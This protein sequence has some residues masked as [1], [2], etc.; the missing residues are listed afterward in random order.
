M[1]KGKWIRT[2]DFKQK[3]S[4]IHKGHYTSE[5]TKRKIS[6]A[7]KISQRGKKLSDEH[8]R[9]IGVSHKN[10]PCYKNPERS[11]KISLAVKGKRR[12]LEQRRRISESHKGLTPWNKGKKNVQ[13]AW[14]KGKPWSLETKLKMSRVRNKGKT[15]QTYR[16]MK[17]EGWSKW[18]KSVFERDN[19]TCQECGYKGDKLEPHHI[20]PKSIYPDLVFEVSNGLTLCKSCHRKTDSYG[21]RPAEKVRS[22][23]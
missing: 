13:V 9:K 19:Y 6:E 10:H 22:L 17:S 16:L 11:K 5:E 14:N 20:K 21:K 23:I 2:E 18:R 7:N 1:T 15:K 3:L 12:T 4:K 8:K